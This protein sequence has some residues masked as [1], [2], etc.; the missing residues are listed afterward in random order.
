MPHLTEHIKTLMQKIHFP[1]EAVKAFSEVENRLDLNPAFA[2]K[3][4]KAVYDYMFAGQENTEAAAAMLKIIA[5]EFGEN[6]LTLNTVFLLGCSEELLNRFRAAGISDEIYWD[7]M[8]DMRCKLLEC[9]EC[10][11]VCGNFVL[12]WYN[13][14]FKVRRFALGR[15]QYERSTF[16]NEGGY[17]TK[18]GHRLEDKSLIINFHIPSSG[19]PLTDD[20]RFD[21]YRRAYEFYKNDFDGKPIVL[22]CNSWLL[23]PK[24]RLFLPSTSHILRFMDDFE[25]V[26]ENESDDFGNAWRVF[27]HWADL[28]L[29][30]WPRDNS[31]R[32]AYC[33]WLE[34]G[35]KAG[36]GYGVIVFD[37][38]KII[39]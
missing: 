30:E 8:A 14:F 4:D 28:P 38:E 13:G 26:R 1:D 2:E 6:V 9:M 24:H 19:I 16:T 21:S 35:N 12:S 20:V 34:V 25:I 22:C 33:E 39:T 17:V 10:E 37:G 11:G 31:L 18:S 29:S 7:S 15:F 23:Y 27:G 3:F 36:S 5:D 32:K